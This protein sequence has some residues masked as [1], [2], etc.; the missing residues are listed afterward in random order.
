MI[1]YEETFQKLFVRSLKTSGFDVREEVSPSGMNSYADIY[2][3]NYDTMFELK[4]GDDQRKG[5]GQCLQYD[6]HCET[7]ILLVPKGRVDIEMGKLATENGLGYACFNAED[8]ELHTAAPY[9]FAIQS[10]LR[11]DGRFT[12]TVGRLVI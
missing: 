8:S 10:E 12:F 2:L 6:N 11:L 9:D 1:Q 7:S 5:I 4:V 3:P